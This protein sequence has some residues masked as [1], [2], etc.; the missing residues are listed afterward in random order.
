VN[1][2][3]DAR[4]LGFI[5]QFVGLVFSIWLTLPGQARGSIELWSGNP[6]RVV[7]SL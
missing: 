1:L 7:R 6:A 5:K 2:I 4:R 3:C